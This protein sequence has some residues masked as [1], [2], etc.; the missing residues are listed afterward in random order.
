MQ[1]DGAVL[2]MVL[3]IFLRVIAQSLSANCPGA[4]HV[5]KAARHIGAL[6]TG[7][8]TLVCWCELA[9]QSCGD[10]SGGIGATGRG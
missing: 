1:R 6:P 5:N 10:G 8:A 4:A 3:R 7:I 9:A 2:N